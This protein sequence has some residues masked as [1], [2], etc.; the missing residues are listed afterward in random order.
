MALI[1]DQYV[2]FNDSGIIQGP[3]SIRG[4]WP[5]LPEQFTHDVDSAAVSFSGPGFRWRNTFTKG[6]LA[7]VFEDTGI[8]SGPTSIPSPYDGLSDVNRSDD[9]RIFHFAVRGG[10]YTTFWGYDYALPTTPLS[11]FRF[12]PERFQHDLDDVSLEYESIGAK[13]S[14]YQDNERIIFD[15]HGNIME[16]ATLD[17]KW[18]FLNGW[19]AAMAKRIR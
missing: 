16:L 17:Y 7:I 2:I 4:K 11:D 10:N 14:F 13:Y 6:S 12:L 15:S 8:V 5:F 19:R 3:A 18:P 9:S 1:G